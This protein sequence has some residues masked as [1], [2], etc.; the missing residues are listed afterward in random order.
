MSALAT[1]T[2]AVPVVGTRW[3]KRVDMAGTVPQHAPELGPCWPTN[4]PTNSKG[5]PIISV[6]GKTKLLHL[7]VYPTVHG[8]IP[9]GWEVDH[10]CHHPDYCKKKAGCPHRRC[11]NPGHWRAVPQE[12]NNLRSG[13]VTAVNARKDECI[14]GHPLVGDNLIVRADRPEHRECRECRRLRRAM[15][16]ALDVAT[17][18]GMGEQ[19]GLL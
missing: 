6:G 7:V 18:G 8:P 12:E 9:P 2:L 3:L 15:A 19:L 16:A 4:G 13:S 14:R 17:A 11:G 5:Y 10:L 1:P